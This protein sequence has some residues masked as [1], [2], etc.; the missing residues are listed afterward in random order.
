MDSRR[1]RQ[2]RVLQT[3]GTYDPRGGGAVRCDE[4]SLE[5]WVSRGA[6][7]SDTV[8]SL[9]RRQRRVAARSASPPQAPA[10]SAAEKPPEP[11]P[12]TP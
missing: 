3:L 9:I 2:G 12:A 11:A 6:Q 4:A 10:P 8:R 5:R 1:K 7:L